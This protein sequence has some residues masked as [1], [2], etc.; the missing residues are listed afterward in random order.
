MASHELKTPVTSIKLYSEMALNHPKQMAPRLPDLFHTIDRQADHLV[1]L[2]ADLLDVSRLELGRVR[3]ELEPCDVQALVN[4]VCAL[5]AELYADHLLNCHLLAG[6][7]FVRADRSR[8]VQVFQNL[9]DNAAKYSPPG[10]PI[11]VVIKANTTDVTVSV[12][13]QGGGISS[14][15]LPH[16]FERFYK[17]KRQ[18]AVT[19]GLGL[20]LYISRELVT[21]HGGKL[22]ATSAESKGSTFYVKLPLLDSGPPV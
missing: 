9:I 12:S 7:V 20:G 21:R 18:Q 5:S 22:W 13:D 4:E 15:D 17:A 10:A 1:S 19:P 6:P 3:L 2:V 14:E 16:I 8:L 11:G